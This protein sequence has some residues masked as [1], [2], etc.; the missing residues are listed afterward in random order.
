MP[1]HGNSKTSLINAYV[2]EFPKKSRF[3]FP[4]Q[5]RFREPTGGEDGVGGRGADPSGD[6]GK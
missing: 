3:P 6:M 5:E 2:Q 1:A 4:C